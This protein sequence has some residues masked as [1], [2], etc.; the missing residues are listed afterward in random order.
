MAEQMGTEVD[1]EDI[2]PDQAGS[3]CLADKG[4]ADEPLAFLPA[5]S[6]FWR[7]GAPQPGFSGKSSVGRPRSMRGLGDRVPPAVRSPERLM[8]RCWL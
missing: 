1:G 6:A 7:R 5:V 4:F 3:E 2:A 8:G